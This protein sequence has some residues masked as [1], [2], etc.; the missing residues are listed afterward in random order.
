MYKN[1][2][3][4]YTR[5]Y[6]KDIKIGRMAQLVRAPRSHRGDHWFESSC[7][8]ISPC[9]HNARSDRALFSNPYTIIPGPSMN[10]QN[11][12][13]NLLS[14]FSILVF[15]LFLFKPQAQENC[16]SFES[17]LSG[18]VVYTPR[19]TVSLKT[20]CDDI[21]KVEFK[22]RYIP[23][24][25]DSAVMVSLGVVSRPPYKLIWNTSNLP[26]QLFK[27]IGLLAEATLPNNETQI[28]TQQGVFLVHNPVPQRQKPFH[29]N[30]KYDEIFKREN[31]IHFPFN[32]SQKQGYA[33]LF[34][35]EKELIVQVMLDDSSFYSNQP[36]KILYDEGIEVLIDPNRS[37][38][39][40][41]S[42]S[43]LFI[44]VPLK[45]LPYEIDY[46]AKVNSEGKFKLVPKSTTVDYDFRVKLREFNGF[47]VSLAIPKKAFGKKIPDTLGCNIILRTFNE[48]GPVKKHSLSGGNR[49]EMYSPVFWPD[50]HKIPKPILM[51]KAVQW[52]IFFLAGLILTLIGYMIIL[53]MTTP[54]GSESHYSEEEKSL[55]DRVK[56][57]IE[58]ELVRKNL[59]GYYV[60][61]RAGLSPQKLSS[62]IK[63]HTGISFNNY[64][65]Y[66][67]T[68]VAKERLRSSRSSESSIAEL[69]GFSSSTE[70][71]KYFQKFYHTTPYKFRM[72]Q[73]VA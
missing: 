7:A 16:I 17:P 23:E 71:E 63:K 47:S 38:D 5:F 34:W 18:S 72:E 70:M 4:H 2:D 21:E 66:C 13:S 14:I 28:A 1:I 65:M 39:P 60:A 67:R 36:G 55:F 24:K 50:Y 61:K 11:K 3:Y 26:N 52:G 69:C 40:Y 15:I 33:N 46:N 32:D 59:D 37:K 42:D 10:F 6:F 48:N 8:Q 73:Q 19:C 20:E 25:S 49:F 29:Y 56:S 62:L 41:P 22:A 54:K 27:G 9:G 30:Y 68:E 57:I 64:L 31:A 51:N 35:N 12:S 44:V 45:G 53:R 58:Q 43:T